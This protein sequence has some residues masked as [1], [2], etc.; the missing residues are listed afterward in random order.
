[1]KMNRNSN[2]KSWYSVQRIA[3]VFLHIL[4]FL[5]LLSG[6]NS[7]NQIKQLQI[8]I[9]NLTEEKAELAKQIKLKN[10]ENEELT[11]RNQTL[12][13]LPDQVK[14]KNLYQLASVN[15]HRFSGFS[16]ED[17]DGEKDTLVVY[18]QPIDEN[19]DKFKAPGTVEVELWNLNNSQEQALLHSW[20]VEFEELKEKWIALLVINYRLT[21]DITGIVENFDEPMTIK[22]K[23]TDYLSGRTFYDQKV[24]EPE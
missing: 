22:I 19:G 5:F 11:K 8:Q 23:F 13:E 9:E 21:F 4:L 24:I 16:D 7:E 3:I 20:P 18:I 15:I 14:G 12:A 17:K 2:K 10:S 6:C 1:M